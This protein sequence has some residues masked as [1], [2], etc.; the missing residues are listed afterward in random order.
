MARLRVAFFA[1]GGDAAG[2][3]GITF[4]DVIMHLWR[5]RRRCGR[6]ALRTV[7]HMD[8]LVRATACGQLIAQAWAD[9]IERHEGMLVRRCTE[10]VGEMHAILHVR[11]AFMQLRLRQDGGGQ[12]ECLLDY[13]GTQPLRAW[14]AERVIGQLHREHTVWCVAHGANGSRLALCRSMPL[15]GRGE[16]GLWANR[17]V[18]LPFPDGRPHLARSEG[19]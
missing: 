9:L 13:A 14:L 3:Y 4:A 7:R 11:R 6:V 18:S 16:A 1:Q 2:R 17:P 12:G 5:T 10:R 19:G 8:D 15:I